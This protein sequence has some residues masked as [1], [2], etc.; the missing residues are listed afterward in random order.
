MK[1]FVI[2]TGF[3]EVLRK[4]VKQAGIDLTRAILDA[5]VIKGLISTT[6]CCTYLLST[7]KLG[8]TV[9]EDDS[10]A[11]TAGVAVGQV[12]VTAAGVLQTRMA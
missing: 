11:N 3:Y 8:L 2:K 7:L 4:G 10:E 12:Y 5:L 9:A 1:Q 6:D